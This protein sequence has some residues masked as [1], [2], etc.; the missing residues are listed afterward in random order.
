VLCP[1]VLGL[2]PVVGH[3]FL[4]G[5]GIGARSWPHR[6]LRCPQSAQHRAESIDLTSQLVEDRL[7]SQS[8]VL[9][10]RLH[11]L[12]GAVDQGRCLGE[13][14]AD[15]LTPGECFGDGLGFLGGAPGIRHEYIVGCHRC[16]LVSCR[17]RGLALA[18]VSDFSRFLKL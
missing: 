12:A 1:A 16:H 5:L 11:V 9:D 7:A 3:G 4:P 13:H 2:D 10:D 18:S 15:V 6:P 8:G 17:V 14:I